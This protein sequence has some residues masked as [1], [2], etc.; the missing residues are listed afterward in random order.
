L[1]FSRTAD[2]DG[3]AGDPEE[4]KGKESKKDVDG[5]RDGGMVTVLPDGSTQPQPTTPMNTSDLTAALEI[6]GSNKADPIAQLQHA[7][8][9]QAA[10]ALLASL[11]EDHPDHPE[12][13]E[14][15]AE[16]IVAAVEA[17]E[18]IHRPTEGWEYW[19]GDAAPFRAYENAVKLYN[20]T[21]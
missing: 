15:L 5:C 12:Q 16:E 18:E 10:S 19:F 21:A 17:R 20:L 11:D 13:C 4:G 8:L 6:L 2:R 3:A 14:A 1:G 9:D 7:L